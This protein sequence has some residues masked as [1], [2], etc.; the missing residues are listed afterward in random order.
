MPRYRP[1]SL[2][3]VRRRATAL[4]WVLVAAAAVA[5][6]AFVNVVLLR[7]AQ[8]EDDPVG[9]LRPLLVGVTS[10]AAAEP[11]GEPGRRPE[12]S[13][14]ATTEAPPATTAGQTTTDDHGAYELA[15]LP[16]GTYAVEVVGNGGRDR[17]DVTLDGDADATAIDI[18]IYF[19]PAPAP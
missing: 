2:K 19:Q 5:V 11:S 3:G 15:N 1:S 10:P 4:R 9:R 6:A 18:L 12:T 7:A 14:A 17:V 13:P 16:P 8:E